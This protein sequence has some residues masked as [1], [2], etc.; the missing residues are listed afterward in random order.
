VLGVVVAFLAAPAH[1]QVFVAF[2]NPAD[3]VG[4]QNWPGALGMQFTVNSPIIVTALGVFDSGADGIAGTLN[5]DLWSVNDQVNP[6][7]S[8]T[9]TSAVPGTLDS[10][11]ADGADRFISLPAPLYLTPG[12]YVIAADGFDN[13]DTEANAVV[14]TQTWTTDDGGGLI[15]FDDNSPYDNDPGVFPTIPYANTNGFAT[16]TFMYTS[17]VPEPGAYA[18]M[19]G[20][21]GLGLAGWRRRK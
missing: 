8:M 5:T 18:L 4:Q 15:T 19:F 10:L 7:A 21:A 13:D 9:F 16:G 1:G 17:A 12:D 20:V 2:Q 14:Q 11:F 3:L 6:L